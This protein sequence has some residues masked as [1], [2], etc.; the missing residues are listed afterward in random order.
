MER[1]EKR[2]RFIGLKLT[3]TEYKRIEKD[4]KQSTCRKL[5]DYL[6]RLIFKKPVT[7]IYRN[8]SMDDF[9]AELI[10]LRTEL[11]GIGN[12]FNQVVKKLHSE[13]DTVVRQALLVA[14]E[15]KNKLMVEHI[16]GINEFIKQ[17]GRQW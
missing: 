14:W 2:T 16:A 10:K 5:S 17:Q 6:R 12:N 3:Q 4:W 1:D 7:V 8:K 13:Q 11:N 15:H 9:M